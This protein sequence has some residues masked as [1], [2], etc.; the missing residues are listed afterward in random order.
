[1]VLRVLLQQDFAKTRKDLEAKYEE[2]L[3]SAIKRP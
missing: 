3:V 1:M 2:E